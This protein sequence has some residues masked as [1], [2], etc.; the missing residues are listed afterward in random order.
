MSNPAAGDWPRA[1]LLDFFGTVVEEIRIPVQEICRR[2]CSASK[3]GIKDSEVVACWAKIFFDLCSQSHGAA[4]QLQKVLEQRSLQAAFERFQIDL[5]SQVLSPLLSDYRSRPTLFPESQ[6]VLSHC[7]VPVCLVTN[8]DNSE[9]QRAVDYTGLRF[10][11]I[12]TSE[13]C[14]A[15]KPRPEAFLEALSRL[16][17]PAQA[18]LHVGD[19]LEGDVRGAHELGIPALWINRRKKLLSPD[20]IQPEYCS[21]DL[22]GLLEIIK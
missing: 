5:D 7:K 19:S 17:L 8:I 21:D 18:V 16:G 13:D 14:R 4:F 11:Y 10:A 12:V 6:S 3:A 20:D 2:V 22:N 15:Y 9:I 1:I